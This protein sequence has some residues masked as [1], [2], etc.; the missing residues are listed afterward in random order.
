MSDTS[1]S[2]FGWD[3]AYAAP[4]SVVNKA[5]IQQNSF[6]QTFSYNDATGINIS[7]TWSSWQ[8][9][10]GG[11]GGDVQMICKVNTGSA[12]GDSQ[13][14]DLSDSQ[15]LI[16]V[17]LATVAAADPVNDK[18]AKNLGKAQ[19]LVVKTTGT[20][21]DPA[22]S[23]ISS[24]YPA[25]SSPLL[26]A[27]L[28]TVFKN[29]FNE[30]IGEFNHVFAV[31]NLNEVA[32][33]DGF[34][35]IK[36]TAFQYAVA[37][38]ED[39]SLANSVFGLI[40]MVQNHPILPTMQQ[41][42]DVRALLNLPTGAN[43]AFVISQAMV[44]QNMLL[45][46]AVATIQGSSPS[47]F[48]FS[49]DGLSV[50]NVKDVVWGN[51]QTENN[52]IISPKIKAHNFILR[53]DDTYIYLEIT[54]AQYETSP[55]VTVHMNTTQ[56]FT[57][58]TVKADNGNY[59]FIPDITGFG[60]PSI[61]ASVSLSEGL[62]ILE[63]ITGAVAAIAGLL[64]AASGIASLV[65]SSAEVAAD[66]AANTAEI[67]IDAVEIAD[68]VESAPEEVQA[69]NDAGADAADAGAA[70]PANPAQVQNCSV[71]T[72]TQFRLVTG[73]TG[74]ISGAVAGSIGIAKAV[75][76]MNYDEIPAFDTFAANCMGATVWPGLSDYQ[77]IGASFRN[78]LV[79][80]L[81]MD[82]TE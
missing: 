62:Q 26:T 75:T 47:D 42:V 23:V 67:T 18:T 24:S 16:Q 49:S 59:V 2:T 5:I 61:T 71:F 15:I 54:N 52:G 19:N 82:A 48:G 78:S 7:G 28:D 32:D 10:P 22:V 74:A 46:G 13:S 45:S 38:S 14:G 70:D 27:V 81:A 57:Y 55:G 58:S 20:G 60:N 66:A 17:N 9:A 4:F 31:M 72:S 12:S 1:V 11:A 35:W 43:S 21:L 80:A 44:A 3:T 8:L 25:V 73:I 65:A 40:S 41:A 33:Q 36:P 50:T 34:Q 69:A 37:S 30:N 29:Y 68:A 76:E 64:F 63:I 51:F 56:K 79:M 77:L 39:R 53:A 6:P